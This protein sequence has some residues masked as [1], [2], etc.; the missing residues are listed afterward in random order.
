[1]T[2]LNG[3]TSTETGTSF[4]A[5]H[6]TGVA[7]LYKGAFGDAPS[8]VVAN[9]ILNN[10]TGGVITGN[11]PGTPNLLLYSPT[12][13]EPAP[14]ANFTSSC[15]GLRC[16]FDASSSTAQ[17]SATY[18]WDWGDTTAAGSGKTTTHTYAG[19]GTYNVTLT[20]TDAGGSSSKTQAVTVVVRLV[21]T[22]QPSDAPP[23]P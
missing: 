3:W 4:A 2:W 21:F 17:A 15:S 8:D 19:A 7:A 1:S 13:P 11:P 23:Y 12:A 18:G 20:V 6:V 5:P 10:A 9:W 14:V 22:V 16:S